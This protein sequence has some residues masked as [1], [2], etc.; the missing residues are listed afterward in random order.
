[1]NRF[2]FFPTVHTYRGKNEMKSLK[3][4]LFDTYSLK[5]SQWRKCVGPFLLG[6]VDCI[7]TQV[8]QRGT[9]YP[10]L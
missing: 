8:F 10:G 1:M 4:W 5:F 2:N 6:R 7:E 9:S 3:M